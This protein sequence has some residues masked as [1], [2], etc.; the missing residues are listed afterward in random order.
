MVPACFYCKI[1]TL[2]SGNTIYRQFI[3]FEKLSGK[4]AD[5]TVPGTVFFLQKHPLL[6][7]I[8]NLYRRFYCKNKKESA[9]KTKS[10][11]LLCSNEFQVFGYLL[12]KVCTPYV[13]SS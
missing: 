11:F 10:E 6:K 8:R 5:F 1:F 3:V 7:K 9:S 2:S 4:S 12:E 13:E